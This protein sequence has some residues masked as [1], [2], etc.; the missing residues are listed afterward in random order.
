MLNK[1]RRNLTELL[2]RIENREY[3]NLAECSIDVP[4]EFNWVRD[5]FEPLIVHRYAD[6]AMLE[7]A[8]DH[9]PGTSTITYT[10]GFEKCNQLLNFFRRKGVEQGDDIFVMC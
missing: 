4:D 3:N 6:H 9:Q 7:M 8:H 10:Q 2:S 1:F 5:V